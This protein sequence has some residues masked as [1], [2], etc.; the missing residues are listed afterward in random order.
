MTCQLVSALHVRVGER[1]DDVSIL[2]SGGVGVRH[3]DRVDPQL[4]LVWIQVSDVD[5]VDAADG[6]DRI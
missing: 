1:S 5:A 2:D 3:G 6:S 4:A